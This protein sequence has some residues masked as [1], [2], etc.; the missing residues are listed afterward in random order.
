MTFD[1][2]RISPSPDF[3]PN[4]SLMKSGWFPKHFDGH[5]NAYPNGTRVYQFFRLAAHRIFNNYVSNRCQKLRYN[6]DIENNKLV[7]LSA[8]FFWF[9]CISIT[10]CLTYNRSNLP[11]GAQR[12]RWM[13]TLSATG[14]AAWC[15]WH[16]GVRTHNQLQHPKALL[17]LGGETLNS[18]R[19]L[20][21][22]WQLTAGSASHLRCCRNKNSC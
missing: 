18:R 1:F 10:L 5:G 13:D 19:Q 7:V 6:L 17:H 4:E 22:R 21:G 8:S 16:W 15:S 14:Q 9:W 20:R 12:V 11:A 3:F 2:V